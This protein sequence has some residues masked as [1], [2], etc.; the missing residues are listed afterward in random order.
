[1]RRANLALATTFLTL[2]ASPGR[3]ELFFT[4]EVMPAVGLPGFETY[5]LTATSDLG[6]IVGFDF[7]EVGNFGVF[8]ELNQVSPGGQSTIYTDVNDIFGSQD[9]SQDT[10]FLLHSSSVVSILNSESA[11][12]LHGAFAFAG[13]NQLTAPRNL[14]FLQIATPNPS[15]ILLRGGAIT[16][17][18][19][20][21]MV[22]EYFDIRLPDIRIGAPADVPLL[23]IP[24]VTPDPVVVTPPPIPIQSPPID[25]PSDPPFTPPTVPEPVAPDPPIAQ[26]SQSPI[27]QVYFGAEVMPTMG[28]PGMTTYRISATS[29]LGNII[30]FDFTEVGSYGI[31][32]E[33]NQVNPVGEATVFNDL[34]SAFGSHDTSEDTQFLLNS[35]DVISLFNAESSTSLH[36]VFTFTGDDQAAAGRVLPFVQIATSDDSSVSL[37]GSAITMRPN[38]QMVDQV[39]EVNLSDIPVGAAPVVELLPIPE[40]EPPVVVTTPLEPVPLPDLPAQPDPVELVNEPPTDYPIEHAPDP[41]ADPTRVNSLPSDDM[42]GTP[43]EGLANAIDAPFIQRLAD[44]TNVDWDGEFNTDIVAI[45]LVTTIDTTVFV[46]PDLSQFSSLRLAVAGLAADDADSAS[47]RALRVERF[48]TT[49]A[50]YLDSNLHRLNGTSFAPSQV[51]EPSTTVQ[52]ILSAAMIG[53]FPKRRAG[54][55]L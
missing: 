28:V 29:D 3:C 44:F 16:R 37:K 34:N 35:A 42:V 46:H 21:Q 12:S 8:G 2:L 48:R 11:N 49:N 22:D 17:R 19:N 23:P 51:P 18:A 30:G 52:L 47:L 6:N 20:G 4:A 36:S 25:P 10:Q 38:G 1:M 50:G 31:F 54:R 5:R 43:V 24:D 7:T 27:G 39:F 53:L 40:P 33:L 26:P 55:I 41:P 13:D 45:D 15:S 14:P 9:T 32:G